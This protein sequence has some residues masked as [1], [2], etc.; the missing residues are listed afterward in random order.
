MFIYLKD[1]FISYPTLLEKNQDS[2]VN[3]FLHSK[4]EKKIIL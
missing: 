4:K 1:T 2:Y 3:R